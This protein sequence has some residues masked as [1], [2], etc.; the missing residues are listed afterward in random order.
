M[1]RLVLAAGAALLL[2]GPA[3]A[4]DPPSVDWS[5][6]DWSKVPAKT[7]TLFWP[8]Q[9]SY[10]WLRSSEH[11]R[12]DRKVAQG[13]ACLDC[14]EGEEKDIG[15]KLVK[16]D[17]RIEPAKLGGKPGANDL[18][19]QVAYDAKFAYIRAQWK[20]QAPRPG[21][22]YPMYRFDGKDWKSYGGPQLDADVQG[23]KKPAIYED[24]F[25]I[26]LDDG[27]VPL[28]AEQGCWIT[29]HNGLRDMPG[30]ATK[31][32]VTA[33]ALLGK[34][35]KKSD[36]RKYIP[37]TRTDDAATWSATKSK[38]DIDQM[39]AKGEFLELMQWRAHR[40]NPVGMADDGY[41]LE[42]RNFDAGK[43]MFSSN[44]DAATKQ[45][46]FM[47]DAGKAGVKSLRAE[48]V[49]KADKPQVLV[50]GQN[51]VAFDPNAGWKEGDLLPQYLIS[52]ADSTGSAADNANVKGEW[53]DG[54]WT[55]QWARPLN[56][57]NPDDKALKD[58]GV[59]TFGFAI[60]DNNITTRGHLVAF[61]RTVGFGKKADIQAVKLN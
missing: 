21:V 58:G 47:F 26:M 4:A 16:G 12:G 6:V 60:H 18:S 30:E 29:C 5:K 51:D 42:Y 61:P 59:Y 35:L 33:N 38:A 13:A 3:L 52:R 45:P 17:P 54:T 24:R 14:H 20:T 36:V 28:F 56:L 22:A 55:V 31:E 7:I 1:R 43:N 49:G 19:I 41:V 9:S 32:Q 40:S 10:Q 53:K 34:E 57:A 37:G 2:A 48:D 23:G 15:E 27:K 50:K 44:M 46:K 11:K 8:G 39:M 25:S